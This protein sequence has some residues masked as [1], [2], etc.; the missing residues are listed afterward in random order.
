MVRVRDL[1][2]KGTEISALTFEAKYYLVGPRILLLVIYYVL[3]QAGRDNLLFLP[4]ES[5]QFT[6][7][8]HFRTSFVLGM[9]TVLNT[10]AYI[11]ELTKLQV[12]ILHLK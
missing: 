8:G 2:W 10:L 4:F 1:I 5:Y 11:S 12:K 6:E 3:S 9:E 7:Q